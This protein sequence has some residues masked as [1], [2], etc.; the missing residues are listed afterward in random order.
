MVSGPYT[1]GEGELKIQQ[2]VIMSAN[3]APQSS[4]LIISDDSDC[5]TLA[6]CSLVPNI[7]IYN[8]SRSTLLSINM[9]TQ[10]LSEYLPS[11][12]SGM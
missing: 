8:E 6:L 5:V 7:T 12:P 10:L 3:G 4:H 9:L 2:E 11:V 1:P